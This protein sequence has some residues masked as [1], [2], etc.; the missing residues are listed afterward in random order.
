MDATGRYITTTT[1]RKWECLYGQDSEGNCVAKPARSDAAP[2]PK[3]D[4][5]DVFVKLDGSD[6]YL[7]SFATY[8]CVG[9]P[10]TVLF[11][12]NNSRELH[13]VR[14]AMPK[15]THPWWVSPQFSGD[16]QRTVDENGVEYPE[17][18][19]GD[20][21]PGDHKSFQFSAILGG[22]PNNGYVTPSDELVVTAETKH[23]NPKTKQVTVETKRLTVRP[24]MGTF[25]FQ[26][27]FAAL[28]SRVTGGS[29]VP[30]SACDD[31]GA[32]VAKVGD[33]LTFSSEIADRR[34]TPLAVTFA[35]D[36]HDEE[37]RALSGFHPLDGGRIEGRSMVWTFPAGSK[38]AFS[39]KAKVVKTPTYVGQSFGMQT[40]PP[41]ERFGVPACIAEIPHH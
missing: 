4:D 24:D 36:T 19:L 14:V 20:M 23:V 5:L 27:P 32:R 18:S 12:L 13:N 30:F 33:V 7:A 28:A 41:G 40:M 15:S 16:T 6:Y 8:V 38:H 9:D 22:R 25:Y 21:A 17:W 3:P 31:T 34:H 1:C 11:D 37:L 26:P 39:F 2:I 35:V 10:I 29:G